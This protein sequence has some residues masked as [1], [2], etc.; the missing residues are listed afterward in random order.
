MNKNYISW[1]IKIYASELS[2]LSSLELNKFDPDFLLRLF[3]NYSN[4]LYSLYKITAQIPDQNSMLKLNIFGS[5]TYLEMKNCPIVNINDLQT[6]RN[7]LEVLICIKSLTKVQ[8][9]IKFVSNFYYN[10]YL[11]A[12]F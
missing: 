12:N 4:Y 1:A 2:F 8:V 3:T 9:K 5:L 6:L 11:N 7:Q 10:F